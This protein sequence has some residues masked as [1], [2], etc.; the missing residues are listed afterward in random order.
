MIL[1]STSTINEGLGERK[2]REPPPVALSHGWRWNFALNF[3]S[4]ILLVIVRSAQKQL[5]ESKNMGRVPDTRTRRRLPPYICP[6]FEL[7]D[8]F[9]QPTYCTSSITHGRWNSSSEKSPGLDIICNHTGS[10]AIDIKLGDSLCLQHWHRYR[11]AL[12]R[13]VNFPSPLMFPYSYM[14]YLTGCLSYHI[15]QG[16]YHWYLMHDSLNI[17]RSAITS[18]KLGCV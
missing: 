12:W 2:V 13:L 10:L 7:Q 11:A 8:S 15:F 9:R 4:R 16:G 6:S 17:H 5:R 1:N 14:Q 18:L 3:L